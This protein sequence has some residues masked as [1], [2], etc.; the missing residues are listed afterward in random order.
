MLVADEV[1]ED[2]E[3]T[4]NLVKELRQLI[5]EKALKHRGENRPLTD[6]EKVQFISAIF[7]ETDKDNS[8]E[9]DKDEFRELLRDLHL[10]YR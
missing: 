2:R 10:T 4:Q 1:L 7:Q 8:G 6:E 5:M 9:I 3:T